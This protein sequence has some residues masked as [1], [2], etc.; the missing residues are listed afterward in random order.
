ML[1]AAALTMGV[2]SCNNDDVVDNAGQTD[3]GKPTYM[4]LNVSFQVPGTYATAD[5][6]AT[7]DESAVKTVSVF[8]FDKNSG[9]LVSKGSLITSDFTQ[10]ASGQKDVYT[11]TQKIATTTGTKSVYVGVNLPAAM[12]VA[13]GATIN[14]MKT[15]VMT[16]SATT[17][18]NISTGFT[19]FSASDVD[20][21][22]VETTDAAYATNNTVTVQ[23][24]R[25]SVKVAVKAAAGLSLA[26]GGGVLSN[27]Q[28]AIH[29][30]NTKTYRYKY[31]DASV[32]K[33]P[34][35]DA[36]VN[37]VAADYENFSDYVAINAA[38]VS[39]NKDLVARYA[40]ENTSKLHLEKESTY[41][42]I[43]ATFVPDA[44]MDGTGTS[45]GSN[46]GQAAKTF[47]MVTTND[48]VK[49]YFDVSTEADAYMALP[50]VAAKSPVKSAA[51][52]G[53]V[54]YY[55]LWLNPAGGYNA[56]RNAFYKATITQIIAPGNPSDLP[57]DPDQP[58]ESPTDLT[59]KFEILPWNLVEWDAI[60]K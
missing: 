43:K 57:K 36:A 5:D 14:D 30:S 25:L 58:I 45:K 4:E 53:G 34:N 60:L 27:L 17:V 32:V 11:A 8:I 13:L 29:Q 35:W 38:S 46:V 47:Y 49:N 51:Y 40:T 33:D 6:N 19:M 26:T 10:S 15:A 24:E 59:V 44:F 41:A 9:I 56:I 54:C 50:A 12:D 7:N 22:L 52:T 48:G 1:A 37:Y 21:T 39:D 42:S 20:A 3:K 23:V 31:T 2:T 55:N 28:F 16:T 18:A